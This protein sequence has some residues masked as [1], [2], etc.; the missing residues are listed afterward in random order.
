MLVPC[1]QVG[2][3]RVGDVVRAGRE[4]QIVAGDQRAD[5][6]EALL[7]GRRGG[8]VDLADLADQP[9]QG[10]VGRRDGAADKLGGAEVAGRALVMIESAAAGVNVEDLRVGVGGPLAQ[11]RTGGDEM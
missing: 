9:L 4:Q 8:V 3:H 10:G 11:R 1:V 6:E 7:A 5:I 2:Q